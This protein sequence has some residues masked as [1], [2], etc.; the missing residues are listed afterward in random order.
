YSLL[1]ER[2]RLKT[3]PELQCSLFCGGLQCKYERSDCWRIEQ[4]ELDVIYSNWIT[5]DLIAMSRPNSAIAG[6]LI[7]LFKKH[8][9]K[10]IFNL[11]QL[12]EHSKCGAGLQKSGFAYDPQLF[13][14]NNIYFYNYQWKDYS[15]ISQHFLLDIIKVLSFSLK[16]GKAAIH[17][18]AGLGR[19]GVLIACY[20]LYCKEINSPAD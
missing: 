3:P 5:D 7:E 2:L 1:S 12:G 6:E 4:R 13:M 15:N 20:L 16:E 11:Q 14:E 19:T 9:V 17:C 10:S 18:H 8:K